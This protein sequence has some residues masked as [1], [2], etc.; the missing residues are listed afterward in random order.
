MKIKVITL[1]E[2]K[3]RQLRIK[4]IFDNKNIFFEFVNG[5]APN[6]ITFFKNLNFKVHDKIY[7]INEENLLKYTNRL[8]VRFGEIGALMAHKYIWE[9]LLNDKENNVY[10]ICEDDFIFSDAFKIDFLDSFDYSKFDLLYLQAV[11][12]HYQNKNNLLNVYKSASWDSNLKIIDKNK[13]IMFEGFAC[14]CITKTGAQ[15]AL[16]YIE[17]NGYDGPIDNLVCHIDNFLSVCPTNINDYVY[18]D[19]T[20]KFSYTHTGDF[21]HKYKLNNI[22]LQSKIPLN[23]IN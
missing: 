18:L 4:N 20:S 23:M 5:V 8:W 11:T 19:D 16:N 6:D 3:E 22:E 10:M 17:N 9:E 1:P 13:N 7:K 2:A 21:I 14:Y 12:A 15:K